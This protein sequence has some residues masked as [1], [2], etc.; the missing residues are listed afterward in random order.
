MTMIMMISLYA[1]TTRKTR[2][3]FHPPTLRYA[4]CPKVTVRPYI[5]L[6]RILHKF[7]ETG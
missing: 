4:V 5:S 7:L 1:M 3:N 2:S 6:V